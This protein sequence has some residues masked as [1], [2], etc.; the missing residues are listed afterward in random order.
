MYNLINATFFVRCS[1][2]GNAKTKLRITCENSLQISF[3]CYG[4]EL[5]TPVELPH[6]L[7]PQINGNI[8]PSCNSMEKDPNQKGG[9]YIQASLHSHHGFA[10]PHVL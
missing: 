5:R 2:A 4:T 3:G 9:E 7:H 10:M 6:S 8:F 1:T